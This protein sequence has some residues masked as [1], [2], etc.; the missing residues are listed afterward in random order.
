MKIQLYQNKNY[1]PFNLYINSVYNIFITNDFFVSNNYQTSIIN[2]ISL[3]NKDIDILI[4]YLNYIN[5]IYNI[6]TGNTK[7]IFIHADYIINHSKE[8]QFQICN[9][10][11]IKNPNN[12][13][14]WEY[15]YLNIDYYN[16]NFKHIRWYFLP[17][18]YNNYLETIYNKY[19]LNIPYNEKPIDV[20]FMGATDPGSRRQIILD[21]VAKK[22]KLYVMNY[23]NDLETYINIIEKS[24]IVLHIYAKDINFSFDYYRLS[25]LYSNKIFVISEKHKEVNPENEN[26]LMNLT[27]MTVETD[28]DSILDVIETYLYKS[29]EEIKQINE[30]VYEVFKKQKMDNCIIDFFNLYIK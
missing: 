10:F 6:D 15:N 4:L 21:K 22:Y 17:L 28:Y 24:K 13:Y 25:L 29:N 12:S 19:K 14:I 7:I 20:L 18:Q 27:N 1:I 26:K 23:V 16:N 11:N 3:Y 8:S 5:D 30:T 2:D 9:Y